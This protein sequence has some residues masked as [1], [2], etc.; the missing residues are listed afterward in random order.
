LAKYNPPSVLSLV[1]Q[2]LAENAEKGPRVADL[3]KWQHIPKIKNLI[4]SHAPRKLA[5]GGT[6]SGKSA[7]ILWHIVTDY[8]LRWNKCDALCLRKT[9]PDLER[10][11]ISDFK[12]YVPED[13]YKFNESKKVATLANGSRVIFSVIKGQVSR[14]YSSTSR[15]SSL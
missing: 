8:C 1:E 15:G 12:Q 4:D 11:L 3:S 5:V 6:G 9:F 14:L 7:G 13:I 10:G 2:K